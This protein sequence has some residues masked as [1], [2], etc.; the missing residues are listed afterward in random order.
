[1]LRD[2]KTPQSD[3]NHLQIS[4]IIWF[5]FIMR[6]WLLNLKQGM[7]SRAAETLKLISRQ[8]ELRDS[9]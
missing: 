1:M 9:A 2:F 3:Q 6:L 7:E 8:I 5:A 4:L